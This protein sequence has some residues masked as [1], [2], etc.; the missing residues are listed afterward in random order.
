MNWDKHPSQP[1]RVRL[2]GW[3]HPTRFTKKGHSATLKNIN[4][5][6]CKRSY[7]KRPRIRQY[8]KSSL[9]VPLAAPEHADCLS[10]IAIRIRLRSTS[11]REIVIIVLPETVA[12]QQPLP[13]APLSLKASKKVLRLVDYFGNTAKHVRKLYRCLHGLV[14]K[15]ASKSK[16]SKSSS[17]ISVVSLLSSPSWH[18][19]TLSVRIRVLS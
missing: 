14:P 18:R 19:S 2:L 13:G 15:S 9:E 10:I 16:S 6:P 3:F 5:R 7:F 11:G 4:R 17:S 12:L 8:V 1:G